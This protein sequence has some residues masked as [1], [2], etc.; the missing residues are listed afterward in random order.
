MDNLDVRYH[1]DGS[2][3]FDF[4]RR[5]AAR[6]RQAVRRT[7]FRRGI[8]LIA[9]APAGLRA[10]FEIG[11]H[12]WCSWRARAQTARLSYGSNERGRS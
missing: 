11:G 4:Y 12:A 10:R 2:I 7:L 3:D 1:P 8:S 9:T 6:Q 5:R